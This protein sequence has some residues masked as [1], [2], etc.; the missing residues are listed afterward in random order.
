MWGHVKAKVVSR[1]RSVSHHRFHCTSFFMASHGIAAI[2]QPLKYV[3]NTH[4]STTLNQLLQSN[5]FTQML[6]LCW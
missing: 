3:G 4:H 6:N 2:V 5:Y 1:W